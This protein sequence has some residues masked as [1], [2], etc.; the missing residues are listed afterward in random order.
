MGKEYKIGNGL[1]SEADRVKMLR[2]YDAWHAARQV[3][4]SLDGH[5]V[6]GPSPD[7][8]HASDDAAVE[9]LHTLAGEFRLTDECG[10]S[11][12]EVGNSI[13]R[14]RKV[15]TCPDCGAKWM[16]DGRVVVTGQ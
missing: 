2:E 6:D 10:H 4:S 16:D 15:V 1:V 14:G 13:E 8:W 7:D 11:S 3:L 9:L 12:A 5:P